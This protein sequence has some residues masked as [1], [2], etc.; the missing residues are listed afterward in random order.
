MTESLSINSLVK[1]DLMDEKQTFDDSSLGVSGLI[2]D[3]DRTKF[4]DTGSAALCNHPIRK[5]DGI[6]V[7][8]SNTDFP[9]I[10]A[11]RLTLCTIHL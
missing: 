2:K 7:Y 1:R 9:I 3:L 10:T 5:L 11:L 8:F 4:A 6:Q